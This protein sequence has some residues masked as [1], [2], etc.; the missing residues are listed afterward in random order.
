MLLKNIAWY[1]KKLWVSNNHLP[2]YIIGIILTGI[3]IVIINKIMITQ[4]PIAYIRVSN[5]TLNFILFLG[6]WGF[7]TEWYAKKRKWNKWKSIIFYII[8][9]SI[10]FIM[11]RFFGMDTIF[12]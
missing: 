5:I 4:S 9:T 10:L 7:F 11:L 8:A 2:T 12:G 1:I 6:I 3:S